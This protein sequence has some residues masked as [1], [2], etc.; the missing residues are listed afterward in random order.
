MLFLQLNLIGLGE[1]KMKKI[2]S[3]TLILLLLIGIIAW[4]VEGS[5]QQPTPDFAIPSSTF[6]TFTHGSGSITKYG[7]NLRT[8]FIHFDKITSLNPFLDHKIVIEGGGFNVLMSLVSWNSS[9]LIAPNLARSWEI[10]EDGKNYTFYLYQ[11]IKWHDDYDFNATDVQFT[12]ETILSNTEIDKYWYN[13]LYSQANINDTVIIDAHTVSIILEEPFSPL[14]TYLSSTPIISWHLFENVNMAKCPYGIY[15]NGTEC[16]RLIGTG[17]F[18]HVNCTFVNGFLVNWA[19]EFNEKCFLGRVNLD[20][21]TLRWDISL[22]DMY[23]SLQSNI[24]DLIPGSGISIIDPQ[25]LDILKKV[26]ALTLVSKYEFDIKAMGF[27]FRNPVLNNSL[28]REAIACIVNKT[29]IINDIYYG[30]AVNSTGPFTPAAEF[31]YNPNV[32]THEFNLTRA[33]ELLDLAGY[34]LKDGIRFSLNLTVGDW[35]PLRINTTKKI[36][37]WLEQV[38]INVTYQEKNFTQF[39]ND[40]Y[41]AHQFDLAVYGIRYN[42]GFDP[43][44][45][46]LWHTGEFLNPWGYNNT[47]INTLL[48][49]GRATHNVTERKAIYDQFQ[50]IIATDLPNVFLFHSMSVTGY[51]NDFHGF[52][53]SPGV[54]ATDPINTEKVWY[55]PTVSG[56]GNC[57]Y[58]VCFIDSEGRRTGYYN[59]TAHEEISNSTYTGVDSDPQLV[60]IR[61][62]SGTY[63][64]TLLGIAND[65]YEFEFVSISADYK[66]VQIKQGYIHEN[67][68]ITYILKV[69]TDG[70]IKVYDPGDFSPHDIGIPSILTKTVIGQ[71]FSSNITVR[72]FNYGDQSETFNVT[73]Y[74]NTTSI[75]TQTVTLTSGNSTTITFTWNTTGF[76]K[77]NYTIWAYA[78]PVQG[79]THTA[80]NTLP[81]GW[82]IV[83]MVGDITG[84]DGWP[85]GKVD[86]LYDI[87][88]V[89]KLFGVEYPD[90]RYNPNYDINDDGKID[91]IND[92]RTV[93]KQFGKTDP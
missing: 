24:I 46:A 83:A 4:I 35:D 2:V 21:I 30:Y 17:P 39:V 18:K 59:G 25:K 40:V 8:A 16:N 34:T 69:Y 47:E 73:V 88:S 6:S 85:D 63:N 53:F 61:S 28:V 51:H 33:G 64:V 75:T 76:A 15:P 70:T 45:Y 68:T 31:W 36:K 80:D 20:N 1:R 89:A 66:N 11:N 56:E 19:L 10:S 49:Q 72:I 48:E 38:G 13:Q 57:P 82:V 92:I 26:S 67:E 42:R 44:Q 43:D 23:D 84:P 81:D 52:E 79:E 86:M 5:T 12:I 50:K 54:E 93:A 37:S 14:L 9:G 27:N 91:M 29:E 71:G 90:P 78:W 22:E 65:T 87:R 62:C 58:K 55:E 7:G 32:Q 74:A 60:N 3:G 77:S 41:V